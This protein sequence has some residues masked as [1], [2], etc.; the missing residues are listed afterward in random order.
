MNFLFSLIC[1]IIS[2]TSLINGQDILSSVISLSIIILS[3]VNLY[4]IQ[5][6]EVMDFNI[7]MY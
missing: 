1:M 7:K 3:V 4:L 6:T 2:V 5:Q